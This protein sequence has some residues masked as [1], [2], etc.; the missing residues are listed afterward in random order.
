MKFDLELLETKNR[1]HEL[2]SNVDEAGQ[3]IGAGVYGRLEENRGK[4]VNGIRIF[5]SFPTERCDFTILAL[6]G[7]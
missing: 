6:P 2:F 3:G 4:T 1:L 7:L 5:Y